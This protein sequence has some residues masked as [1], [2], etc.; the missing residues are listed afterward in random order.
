L[1][2]IGWVEVLWKLRACPAR[3]FTVKR[4]VDQFPD[5]PNVIRHAKL[6]RWGNAERLMHAAKI[7]VHRIQR[8]RELRAL[9]NEL[10]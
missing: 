8:N 7:V 2:G 4:G 10:T 6:Y 3:D 5:A 1:D 9:R